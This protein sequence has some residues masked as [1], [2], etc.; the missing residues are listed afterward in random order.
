MNF[1]SRCFDL[2]EN[3]YDLDPTKNT[4]I[5]TPARGYVKNGEAILIAA[6]NPNS[7][8]CKKIL[9]SRLGGG[10]NR[11]NDAKF[12]EKCPCS[13]NGKQISLFNTA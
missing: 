13:H 1:E 12:S 6:L 2:L 5:H 11:P 7:I 8:G 4:R 9:I 10:Q 3:K